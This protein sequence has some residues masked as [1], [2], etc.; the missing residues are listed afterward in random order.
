MNKLQN[1]RKRT[2]LTTNIAL[3]ILAALSLLMA[4]SLFLPSTGAYFT[5]IKSSGSYQ[6]FLPQAPVESISSQEE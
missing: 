2:I 6:G 4:F 5:N 3:F 1:K